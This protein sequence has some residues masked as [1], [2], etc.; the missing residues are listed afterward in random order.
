MFKTPILFLVFNRPETTKLVFE[1]IRSV[2]PSKLYIC[3]DGPRLNV[4]NDQIYCSEVRKMVSKVDWECEVKTLFRAE[5]KGCGKGVS[6]AITWFFS[7][8]EEGI[9]LEDD[10]LPNDSFYHYCSFLLEKYRFESRIMHIGANNFL[11]GTISVE[12]DIYF[13]SISHIWGWATWKRAWESYDFKLKHY[14]IGDFKFILKKYKWPK[15]ILN[16]WI[17]IYRDVQLGNIDTWDYQWN[18][19]IH[20]ANG[21][22]IIPSQN[23]VSNL[24]FGPNAT[25]TKTVDLKVSNL[26]SQNIQL[27]S[28]PVKKEINSDA[29]IFTFTKVYDIKKPLNFIQKMY[30]KHKVKRIKS[31]ILEI[32]KSF[33][34]HR[35]K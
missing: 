3:A 15:F 22:S 8:E 20:K 21:L 7:N 12:N 19:A 26:T 28:L 33:I 13:S 1:S 4:E 9:I 27:N 35:N 32:K 30:L 24:G 25:H 29:D 17:S 34:E 16:Y 23:L 18:F 10:C 6:E 11:D 5:N 14:T 2:K 31:L